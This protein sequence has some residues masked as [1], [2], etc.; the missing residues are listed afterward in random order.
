M[1]EIDYLPV[2]DGSK[3]GDAIAMRFTRP[4]TG[5]LAHVII[6]A[7]FEDDGEALVDHFVNVYGTRSVD[8]VVLSH[9]DR[10][11]R[12]GVPR[13]LEDLDVAVL[14]AHNPSAHGGAGL[15][16]A[17]KVTDLLATAARRGT[18]VV[19]PFAGVGGFGGAL[20]IAGPSK[21]FYKQCIAEELS[22]IPTAVQESA[23]QAALKA[24]IAQLS[25]K[26]LPALPVEVPFLDS[27]GTKPL[28]N[29]STVI[30]LQFGEQRFVFTADAGVQA[31]EAAVDFLEQ[32]GR[33]GRAP[34][35]AQVAHH[36][37]RRNASSKC[38]DR[39]LG[40]QTTERRG[41]GLISI[42][43]VAEQDPRYPSPRVTNAFD[44]RGYPCFI[45]AGQTMCL[46]GEGA[47]DR[48]WTP[49]TP[50]PPRDETIDDRL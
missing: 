20:L 14:A 43:Q 48:G 44:R 26:V 38:L 6:D 2:G 35:M 19:E 29:S 21:T 27:G 10:D 4:D 16:V 49:M 22:R 1:F 31:L 12:G 50:L 40:K 7:G 30:D 9:P 45:N 34:T 15:A 47:P 32:E 42:S 36:G 28:N 39:L 24:A 5:G 33:T 17:E 13:V 3:S 8:L 37:S 25:A 46:S 11:H 41:S 23:T 18:K